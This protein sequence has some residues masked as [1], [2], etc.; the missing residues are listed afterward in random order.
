MHTS[1][2]SQ[3]SKLLPTGNRVQ[4]DR[5]IQTLSKN[6]RIKNKQSFGLWEK[7]KLNLFCPQH[8]V[9]VPSKPEH[10]N[11]PNDN[12]LAL[13]KAGF[14]TAGGTHASTDYLMLAADPV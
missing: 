3:D 14:S 7:S 5:E 4:A 13:D 1:C 12:N 6:C 11:I 9:K 10:R 2:P 8:K